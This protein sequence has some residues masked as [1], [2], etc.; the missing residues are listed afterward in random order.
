[1]RSGVAWVLGEL[2]VASREVTEGLTNTVRSLGKPNGA[3]IAA[4]WESAFALEKLRLLGPR[5]GRQGNTAIR[6]LID[7]LPAGR[8][9]EGA[10]RNFFD[11]LECD[12][13]T[14]RQDLEGWSAINQCDIV[15]IVKHE[16]HVDQGELLGRLRTSLDFAKDTLGRR[17][18]YIVWLCGHLGIRGSVDSVI[19]ATEHPF[20][21]VRNIACE[22]LGKIG[23]A[24]PRVI[25]ALEA[26]LIKDKYYR[27][28]YHAAWSLCELGSKSSLP[29]LSRA[30]ELEEVRDVREEMIRVRG[31]LQS[32]AR[33]LGPE[34]PRAQ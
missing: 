6:F 4:W 29:M 28:R 15:T 16:S 9:L 26:R 32:E 14:A 2:G 3:S 20:G 7:N 11:S 23:D 5:E 24:S 19:R 31:H 13:R 10:L 30:V 27:A 34:Q 33:D 21:S 25:Q 22:A 1:M 8:T 18:Y 17:C 12:R